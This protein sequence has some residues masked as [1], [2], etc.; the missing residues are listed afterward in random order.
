MLLVDIVFPVIDVIRMALRFEDNNKAIATEKSGIIIEKLKYYVSQ[1]CKM[2]NCTLVA[3]RALC[4]MVAYSW[5]E[6][7]IFEHRV[8]LLENITSLSVRIR[9]IQVFKFI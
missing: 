1:D 7:L 5:G 9:N 6:K 8:S 3:F 4:N 2:P